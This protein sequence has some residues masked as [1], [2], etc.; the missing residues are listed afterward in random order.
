MWQKLYYPYNSIPSPYSPFKWESETEV[1][2][3]TTPLS[4]CHSKPPVYWTVYTKPSI[5][6]VWPIF[7]G[8]SSELVIDSFFHNIALSTDPTHDH[9][10]NN[11]IFFFNKKQ[12]N[13]FYNAYIGLRVDPAH[14]GS[15]LILSFP[16]YNFFSMN[17]PLG[18]VDAQSTCTDDH[19]FSRMLTLSL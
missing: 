9:D 18:Q 8:L 15:F 13:L 1:E 16:S 14:I 7:L 2:Q 17:F 6:F 19:K 3:P 5:C 12:D 11:R 10:N 4:G